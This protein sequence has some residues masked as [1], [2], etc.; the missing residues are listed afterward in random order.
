M[1]DRQL[2]ITCIFVMSYLSPG[3]G[4]LHSLLIHLVEHQEA[5]WN[6]IIRGE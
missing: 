5:A 2:L 1:T 4:R 6:G 3:R